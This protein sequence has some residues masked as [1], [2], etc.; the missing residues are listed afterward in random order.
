[1]APCRFRPN[2]TSIIPNITRPRRATRP[3]FFAAGKHRRRRTNSRCR[4]AVVL[5]ADHAPYRQRRPARIL[6][7]PA[8]I[9]PRQALRHCC[10]ASR[11]YPR[12]HPG[13]L[14]GPRHDRHD[15][16]QGCQSH[17][18]LD[19]CPR[20]AAAR[21]PDLFH[22]PGGGNDADAA[23]RSDARAPPRRT[24]KLWRYAMDRSWSLPG[25]SNSRPAD[26]SAP[27]CCSADCA[28]I[29][30]GAKQSPQCFPRP[31]ASDR[32]T[33]GDASILFDS[34]AAPLAGTVV[35]GC[36]SSSGI[37]CHGQ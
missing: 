28:A 17:V 27:S 13:R 25:G 31:H 7:W 1:M 20:S 33:T 3:R 2:G 21:C 29:G 24:V 23:G 32:V 19:L 35:I 10:R 6:G 12:H 30:G 4:R 18:V 11:Q 22:G 34:S 16:R 5:A 15:P 36:S 37:C 14:P 9:C 26:R 8:G